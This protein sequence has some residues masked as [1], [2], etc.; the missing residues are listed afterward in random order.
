[1]KRENKRTTSTSKKGVTQQKCG[2][3]IKKGRFN[4]FSLHHFHTFNRYDI[5]LIKSLIISFLEFVLGFNQMDFF[6]IISNKKS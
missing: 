4:A 1:M 2:K 6:L 3:V 5:I